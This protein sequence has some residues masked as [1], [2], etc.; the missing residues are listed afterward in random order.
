MKRIILVLTAIFI[1]LAARADYTVQTYQPMTPEQTVN[2]Y[3]SQGYYNP[4]YCQGTYQNPYQG[5]YT[6]PYVNQGQYVNP[7]A[8]RNP[9]YLNRGYNAIPSVVNSIGASGGAG[10]IIKNVGQSMLY[11]MLR[12]Y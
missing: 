11:S 5:Y 6:N 7:Y 8:Y 1:G 2:Y 9:Y 10:Q 12:G 4:G 3:G